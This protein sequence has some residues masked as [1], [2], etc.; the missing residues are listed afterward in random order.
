MP[1]TV[2][3][4]EICVGPVRSVLRMPS[5]VGTSPCERATS[6]SMRRASMPLR[7]AIG[8]SLP[9]GV[10]AEAQ[11]S[12]WVNGVAESNALPV[13]LVGTRG[14][15]ADLNGIAL[16][17]RAVP[18]MLSPTTYRLALLFSDQMPFSTV[19]CEKYTLYAKLVG[20][21]AASARADA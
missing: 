3:P 11:I 18:S 4:F 19:G 21:V 9:A 13:P 14:S 6:A 7:T 5:H 8:S 1:E 17:I 16:T 2:K 20:T 10:P 15:F 12:C